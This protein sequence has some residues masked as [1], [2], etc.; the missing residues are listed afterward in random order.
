MSF[1]LDNKT[2]LVTGAASGIGKATANKL[3]ALGANLVLADINV[4]A[5]QALAESLQLA[6]GIRA[7]FQAADIA[8]AE[9]VKALLASI[10]SNEGE[11]DAAV[12]NAGIVHPLG[13]IDDCED[14]WAE[15]VFRINLMG[16]FLCLKYELKLMKRQRRGNIVNVASVAGQRSSGMLAVYGASKHGVVGLTRSAAT[17]YAKYNIRVNAVCPG[18]VNTDMT[19][20]SVAANEDS[21]AHILRSI[22]MGRFAEAEEIASAIAWLCGDECEYINGHCMTIDG[23]DSA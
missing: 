14:E 5:G 17:E 12:N 6:H 21:R 22:P 8:S 19:S 1:S 9:D 15:K 20:N 23:A 7:R 3:A 4:G 10:E 13:K 18:A 2:V 16:N 11:L